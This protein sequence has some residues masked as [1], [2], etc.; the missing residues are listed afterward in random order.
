MSPRASEVI[1]AD[2]KPKMTLCDGLRIGVA[3]D[4]SAAV[5]PRGKSAIRAWRN[6]NRVGSADPYCRRAGARARNVFDCRHDRKM[7]AIAKAIE[8]P[9]PPVAM[10]ADNVR[11]CFLDHG[12][13]F[14]GRRAEPAMSAFRLVSPESR[15]QI[16]QTRACSSNLRPHC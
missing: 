3:I 15:R 9:Q 8:K 7:T 5:L 4:T 1:K 12:F 10:L 11:N 16:A 14:F 13:R 6:D 2:G